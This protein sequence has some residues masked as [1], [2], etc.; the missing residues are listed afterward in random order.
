MSPL[1]HMPAFRMPR[2]GVLLAALATVLAVAAPASA[3]LGLPVSLPSADERIDTPVGYVEAAASEQGASTCYDLATP[4]LPALPAVPALPALPVPVPAVPAIP[5]P[6]AASASC[7]SAGLDGA[8]AD[9]GIDAAG[10]HVST[11]IQADSPVSA[12]EIDA[13][14]SQTTSEATGFFEGLM[15]KVLGWF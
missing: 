13:T 12:E 9:L 15:D 1:T 4:A 11:G 7:V 6:S 10:S 14:A 2:P 3:L 8:S 5:T